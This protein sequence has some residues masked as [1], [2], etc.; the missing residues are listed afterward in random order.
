MIGRPFRVATV[1][2]SRTLTLYASYGEGFRPKSGFDVGNN[3]FAPEQTRSYE[4]GGKLAMFDARLTGTVAI[5]DEA[6]HCLDR[7]SHQQRLFASHR[8]SS[9]PQGGGIADGQAA[10]WLRDRRK[11]CVAD[12]EIARAGV[13][14]NFGFSLCRGDRQ[15][16]VPRN[17]ASALL[18]KHFAIGNRQASIG[19]TANYIGRRVGKTGYRYPDGSL[20]PLPGYRIASLNGSIEIVRC[21]GWRRPDQPIRHRLLAQF[22]FAHMGHAGGAAPANR[23]ATLQLLELHSQERSGRICRQRPTRKMLRDA[24]PSQPCSSKT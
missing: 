16:N 23:Q 15:I 24:C 5:D 1:L 8:Q 11:S 14:P 21:C 20:F 7:R 13:D 6:R 4:A 3:A 18:V 10:A 19:I 2:P 17:S 9:Q 22:P 12:A